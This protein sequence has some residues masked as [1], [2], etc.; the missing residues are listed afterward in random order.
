MLTA[1]SDGYKCRP[2]VLLKNKRPIKEVVAKFKNKLHLSWA[3]RTFFNDELIFEYLQG[4][5]GPQ[6]FGKR[7]ISWDAYRCHISEGTKKKLKQLQIDTVVIPGGCTK[8]IQVCL[9]LRITH[10]LPL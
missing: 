9:M 5:F 6:L 10:F 3:G 1:R 2:F 4:I 7:L 8:F